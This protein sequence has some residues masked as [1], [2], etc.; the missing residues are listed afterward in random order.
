MVTGGR[1]G[2]S[3]G[4]PSPRGRRG[5]G[6][7]F[8]PTAGPLRRAAF[9]AR[10]WSRRPLGGRGTS[11]SF[12]SRGT[13]RRRGVRPRRGTRLARRP[14]AEGAGSPD[15]AAAVK[16]TGRS[17]WNLET[18]RGEDGSRC[19]QPLR[20]GLQLHGADLSE[21]QA[22][23]GRCS[24]ASGFLCTLYLLIMQCKCSES[25]SVLISMAATLLLAFPTSQGLLQARISLETPQDC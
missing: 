16:A 8:P 3:L 24:L 10:P 2:R 6:A 21:S 5:N 18:A 13:T 12:G 19:Q 22:R 7:V 25:K 17:P 9:S 23:G 14:A 20:L 4:W 11:S 1:P 15:R